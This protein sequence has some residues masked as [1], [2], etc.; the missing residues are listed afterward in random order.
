MADIDRQAVVD[1]ILNLIDNASKYSDISRDIRV[2][3]GRSTTGS[4]V[5]VRDRGIGMSERVI[6]KIF[7][8]LYRGPNPL[9]AGGFGL[10][11]F[12][13]RHTMRA[14][15]GEVEVKSKVGDGSTFRLV[16]PLP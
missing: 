5:E 12:L 14:H 16:F 3:V 10:G 6:Q 15:R 7:E 2:S 1:A 9:G 13:V 8:P 11:L 4:F